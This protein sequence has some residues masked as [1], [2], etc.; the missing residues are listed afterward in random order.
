M[1]Q[2]LSRSR[3][4]LVSTLL[5]SSV[6]AVAHAGN[7]DGVLVGNQAILN[8]GAVTA[9]VSDGSSAWYNPAGLGL[10]SR[11]QLDVTGS[12]YGMNI[13]KVDSLFVGPNG[14]GADAKVTD[15]VLIPSLLSY[16]REISDD[17]V[18]GIAIFIPR[19]HDF[20]LRTSLQGENG[21]QFAA[22]VNSALYEYDYALALA[23]RFGPNFRLGLTAAGVYVSSREFTQ[24]AAGAPDDAAAGFYNGSSSMVVGNYGVRLTVGMQWEPTRELDLGVSIQSPMLTGWSDVSRTVTQGS[25]STAGEPHFS[26]EEQQGPVAV[27]DFTTPAR[28]RV[29]MAYQLGKTQLLLDGD[30]SSP[31]NTPKELPRGS[32]LDRE[33]VPNGRVGAM[34][35]FSPA[36]TAGAG[37]FTDL[38]GEKQFKMSF[39][40]VAFGLELSTAHTVDQQTRDL[41]FS[42]TLGGRY[43]YGWGD[44][45]GRRLSVEGGD[46]VAEPISAAARVH[47]LAFNLGGGV[48]F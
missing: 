29:G 26:A 8:G 13:Y 47:E 16:V 19:T 39:V 7:D 27:W 4:T 24:V 9:V 21:E 32:F 5:V 46:L 15:W 22:T 28:L 2:M 38:S 43:A 44:L 35:V 42:T 17:M 36:M 34:H 12:A 3:L 48:N 14:Q 33:W 41:T 6:S 11:N 18:G 45:S 31:M 10:A 25:L 20:D 1:P 23:K 40:G 37:V 30:I